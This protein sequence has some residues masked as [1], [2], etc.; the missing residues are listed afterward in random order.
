MRLH[1]TSPTFHLPKPQVL[2]TGAPP[3]WGGDPGRRPGRPGSVASYFCTR[4]PA[5]G[6]AGT[7]SPHSPPKLCL[8]PGSTPAQGSESAV[9]DAGHQILPLPTAPS[10]AHRILTEILKEREGERESE[11]KSLAR[12]PLKRQS[13]Q[14]FGRWGGYFSF[15][16]GK[17]IR[18]LLLGHRFPIPPSPP[19]ANATD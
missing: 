16:F 5:A 13:G 7:L 3:A 11:H 2:K 1:R 15:L 9:L 8:T 14:V 19:P 6:S 10:G 12:N 17:Q 4:S 18:K